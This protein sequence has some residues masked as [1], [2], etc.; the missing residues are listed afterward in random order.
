M[1]PEVEDR[2]H[3]PA[4]QRVAAA[5]L[6]HA[7][8]RAPARPDAEDPARA[9][10]ASGVELDPAAHRGI[11][12]LDQAQI[13]GHARNEEGGHRPRS[14]ASSLRARPSTDGWIWAS[15]PAI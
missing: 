12:V 9:R 2:R 11:R 7:I 13:S 4:V 5:D 6:G 14:R 8:D 1:A 10:Y 15:M 3:R